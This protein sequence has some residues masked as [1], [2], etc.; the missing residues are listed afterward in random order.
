M[1]V[2]LL[3]L[4]L[5]VQGIELRTS[6]MLGKDHIIFHFRTPA[7]FSLLIWRQ[8]ITIFTWLGLE[9]SV[10]QSALEP[11]ILLPQAFCDYRPGYNLCF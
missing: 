8:D 2:H 7:P 11:G 10:I 9:L 6:C 3:I 5:V 4:F 1:S